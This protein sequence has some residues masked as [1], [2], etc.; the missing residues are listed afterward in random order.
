MGYI[1]IDD[2]VGSDMEIIFYGADGN[3]LGRTDTR[4]GL[5]GI[6]SP[7]F[8]GDIVSLQVVV[9]FQVTTDITDYAWMTT[10]CWL[11]VVTRLNTITAGL[12]HTIDEHRLGAVNTDMSGTFYNTYQM[13]FLLPDSEIEAT[14]RANGWTMAFN[15][16]L[17]TEVG[18]GIETIKSAQDTCG[19]TLT[20]TWED[21]LYLDS[22]FGDW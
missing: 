8:V 10:G 9:Y 11:T 20:L 12:V 17:E 22:W 4:L 18:S 15:A 6:R 14:G 2:R 13:S 1:P 3:E 19:T 7:D 16:R 21:G 5:F